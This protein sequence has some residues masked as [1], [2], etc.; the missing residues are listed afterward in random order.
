MKMRTTKDWLLVAAVAAL[1]VLAADG[2]NVKTGTWETTMTTNTAGMAMP[3]GAMADMTPQQKAQ[4]EALMKQLAASGPKTITERSCITDKDIS[5]GAFH[6]PADGKCTY[7][8]VVA[9][10]KRQEMTFECPGDKGVTSGRMVVDAI[11]SANVKGVMQIRAE[12][13]TIDSTFKSR[14][15]GPTCAK[16]DKD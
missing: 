10:G 2:L 9:T 16:E 3:A 12:G 8:P 5:E 4:M 1:P 14:W 7:K 6:Q 13:M 15:L 11:D